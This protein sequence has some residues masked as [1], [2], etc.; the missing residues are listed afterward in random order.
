MLAFERRNATAYSAAG[1]PPGPPA[2]GDSLQSEGGPINLV[3][4]RCL[5]P[6]FPG[7]LTP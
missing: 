6:A 4:G 7:M 1:T 3:Y 5:T 2:Y